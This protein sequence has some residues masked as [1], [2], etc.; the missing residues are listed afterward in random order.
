MGVMNAPMPSAPPRGGTPPRGDSAWRLP[1]W[2]IDL[3]A[4]AVVLLT[5]LFPVPRMPFADPAALMLL[6]VSAVVAA[7]ALLLRR[8]M[9][10]TVLAIT[11]LSYGMTVLVH[12]PMLGPGIA[13][14]IA[15]YA[16][17]GRVPRIAAL[18]GGGLAAV[19]IALLSLRTVPELTVDPRVFQI[20]AALAVAVALGDSARSRR[21]YLAAVT[22]RAERAERSREV[23]AQ[24]RVAEERLRIA[25]DLHD[26]VAHRISVISLNAGVAS[27]A[28]ESRP[29][30]AREALGTIRSA[31]RGVLSEISD[32][33]T[34]LRSAE[35]P[36]DLIRP[37]LG[38]GDLPELLARMQAAG[39]EI[40][41]RVDGEL[42]QVDGTAGQVGY[43][44][45]QEGLTNAHKHGRRR[46][47]RVRIVAG[48]A[49]LRI[50]ILNQIAPASSA[51]IE[52]PGDQLGLLG[53]R[54]RVASA[55]GTVEAGLE[56][57]DFRLLVE[58]PLTERSRG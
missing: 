1:E 2:A 39:L 37:Q 22:E 32:L 9:P 26:T 50:E 33:L 19:V 40:D 48:A 46:G 38:M 43:R 51:G 36:A 47:A 58:L 24:R 27:Q 18:I 41:L 16:M 55:G 7:F 57:I 44:V 52:V 54:E 28:L 45:V 21:E 3:I 30:K 56:G 6:P 42:E 23:E 14:V 35:D 4:M 12:V 10:V 49:V 29:E 20:A 53:I 17:A 11:L 34:H 8:R 15:A 13:A 31:A 25:R 5:G